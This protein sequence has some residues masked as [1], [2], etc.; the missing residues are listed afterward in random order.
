MSCRGGG[1]HS[2]HLHDQPLLATSWAQRGSKGRGTG[3]RSPSDP[4]LSSSSLVSSTPSQAVYEVRST[5]SSA[6]VLSEDVEH[7]LTLQIPASSEAHSI[8]ASSEAHSVIQPSASTTDALTVT[9]SPELSKAMQ[10][11]PRLGYGTRG[12]KCI[13]KANNSLL[14]LQTWAFITT[15]GGGLNS[16]GFWC[17]CVDCWEH[18]ERVAVL[19][20][21]DDVSSHV[22]RQVYAFVAAL[23][24]C[25]S[26]FFVLIEDN[27][28]LC[29]N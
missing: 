23:D 12:N 24:L 5:S 13:V 11:P 4:P 27:T 25:N 2:D 16:P 6:V 3:R 14:R 8:P 10:F 29:K 22:M 26:F 19:R 28:A 1:R 9:P 15:I 17:V 7:H 18:C 20:L 21:A